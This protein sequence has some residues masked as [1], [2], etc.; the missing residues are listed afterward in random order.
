VL[1]A[2]YRARF[3]EA[4][5]RQLDRD[6]RRV[7]S[8]LRETFIDADDEAALLDEVRWWSRRRDLRNEAGQT[9]FDAFLTRLKNDRLYTDYGLWESRRRP[10]L[11][12]LY[13]EV[14]ER[15]GELN[16]LIA[17]NSREFGG[18]RP[19]SAAL[20]GEAQ[21][22]VNQELVGRTADIILDRLAG[23]T[24]GGESRTIADALTGL[25]PPEQAAVLRRIRS[26]Y[27]ETDWTGLFGRFGEAWEGGML[28]WLFE[29]LTEGD[30]S[31]VANA[32]KASGVLPAQS[33]DALVAGRGWGA[34][35]CP[36]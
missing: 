10:Y 12:K 20:E 8:I 26:R 34:S 5:D 25:P 27:A 7:E 16:T 21:P 22:G 18:Y 4:M 32:L 6:V 14:E 33:V 30:R 35:T 23:A 17:Q 9:Y 24:T 28:Y 36:T 1:R 29:D 13:Q 3:Y 11:D 31:R 19:A 2:P 15:V